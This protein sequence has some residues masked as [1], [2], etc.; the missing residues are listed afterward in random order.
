M[1]DKRLQ[2]CVSMVDGTGTVCDVGTDHAY[3]AAELIKS[4][5]CQK[6]IASDVREGPLEAAARTVEKNGLPEKIELVL[7]NGL[8][9]INL[10]GVSDI[11]IAGMGGETI[12]EILSESNWIRN[13]IN[14][15][16]QPMTK[17]EVLRKW[18]VENGFVTINEAAVEESG[19]AYIVIKAAYWAP[20]T[21]KLSELDAYR[22]HLDADDQA[23][24][25]F[26]LHQQRELENKA[27]GM[28]KSGRY[29]LAF[30]YNTLAKNLFMTECSQPVPVSEIYEKLNKTYPF[31]I[32]EK[33]DN[34]GLLIDSEVT[35]NRVLLTLDIDKKSVEEACAYAADLI[36]SHHPI[37]FEPLKKIK[38]GAPVYDIIFNNMSAICM[39][40]NVDKA[41]RGTNWII[42]EL[43]W[44][45]FGFSCE[46]EFFED[47]GDGYGFG[48]VCD[49]EKEVSAKEFGEELKKI[50][51]CQFVR[52]NETGKNIKRIGFCS[53][54]GGSMLGIAIEKGC[55][56]YITGDVKHDVWID[57]K[58]SGIALYDCGHFHTE[59]IVLNEIRCVLEESFPQ[60]DV[61]IAESSADPVSYIG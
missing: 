28:E 34:S 22:G 53:G 8:E 47:C 61:I 31:A 23:A 18:L 60:L 25:Q 32:Q 35:V 33:W 19:K 44:D 21:E 1:L 4:G 16:L 51:D 36:I 10:D 38:K 29:A 30:H 14:L 40:T 27:K 56:A 54:S 42:K 45:T 57:A 15:V 39:H 2:L 5:K 37:I 24:K 58:N 9:G 3:L 43:L 17:V 46:P 20:T 7:A 13:G 52:Y 12:I 41:P 26:L 6:V 50:F 48:Y 11:V 55:D 49:L 59:N